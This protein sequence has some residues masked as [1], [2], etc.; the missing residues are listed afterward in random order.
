MTFLIIN[1]VDITHS[2]LVDLAK[3]ADQSKAFYDWIED[4]FQT[5]LARK[6]S[7]DEILRTATKEEIYAGIADCYS[8]GGKANLPMLFD[9]IGRSYLHS[10]AC[11]YLFSWIIRDAPQQR[12]S[13]LVQRIVRNSGKTRTEAEIE[14]ISALIYKYRSNVKTFSWEAVREVIIDRLEGSRRSIKGHEKEIIVRTALLT[15]IQHYYKEHSSYGQFAGV[16]IADKQVMVGNESFDVSVNLVDMNGQCTQR[17]L[18]P[19]KTRETEGGGHSH[20]FTRDI[21]SAINAA[22]F[23]NQNDYLIVIIVAKN[24]SER[25]TEVIRDRV[26]HAVIFDLN[27]N[28]FS[29]FSNSEQE[30]LNRFVAA[31]FNGTLLPKRVS[32]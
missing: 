3:L 26:D 25:E 1:G 17:I 30:R 32:K 29:E 6:Q 20:L 19:I 28:E 12:L 14:A 4:R 13:P 24:W 21:M 16:E 8:A 27:P 23:D 10:K 9:G 5:I 11:Y 22:K 2:R 18:V 7:L 15:A 31:V